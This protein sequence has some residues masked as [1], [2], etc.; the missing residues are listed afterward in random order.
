MLRH[1]ANYDQWMIN[2]ITSAED[3]SQLM[4]LARRLRQ[5]YPEI[6]SVVNN[7][8]SRKASIAMGEYEVN[9][10]GEDHLKDTIDSYVFMI[11]ANSFF[12][13]NTDGARVLYRQTKKYADLQGGET[14]LDL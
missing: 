2:I 5:K 1:S 7:V 13:T 4:P 9:L 12:Q 11:S 6:I 14:V 3:H 10:A 8:T